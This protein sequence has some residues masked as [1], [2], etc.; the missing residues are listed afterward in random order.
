MTIDGG[1]Y[2]FYKVALA[3]AAYAPAAE[4]LCAERGMQ[5]FIP[6]TE[7]HLTTA[8]AVALDDTFGP[9]GRWEY[10]SIMGIYPDMAT[11][12]C[13][14]QAFTSSN[15]NCPWSASDG[16]SFWVS[17]RTDIS[18]PNGDN[19][20]DQSMGYTFDNT[21]PSVSTYNDVTSGFSSRYFMCDTGT[22]H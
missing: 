17:E 1:G 15:T 7:D 4:A 14:Y 22:K 13:R 11:A 3:D 8:H 6:R 19:S 2:T 12:R 16:G 10:L 20:M 21:S 18:E 5:L 9:T